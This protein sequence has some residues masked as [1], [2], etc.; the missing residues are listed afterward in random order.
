MHEGGLGTAVT[1]A[2]LSVEIETLGDCEAC[3]SQADVA[4]HASLLVDH[5]AKR[6][7]TPAFANPDIG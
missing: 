6:V 5:F 4:R 1:L 7:E 3:H 2:E